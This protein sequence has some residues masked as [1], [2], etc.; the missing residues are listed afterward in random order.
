MAPTPQPGVPLRIVIVNPVPGV[1]LRVQSGRSDLLEPS[2]ASSGVVEFDLTLRAGS[3]RTGGQPNFL[4]AIA[5][6][7]PAARFIYVNAG[8]RCGQSGTPWDR[9]AKIP[10]TGITR[11][12]LASVLAGT[13]ARLEVRIHG[14]AGD[15]GPA[16][17]SVPL[18]P[19]GWQVVVDGGA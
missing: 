11:E 7:P 13:G 17:A 18:L 12:Q 6:G 1:F 3:P 19:P 5:Q 14:R 16:C 2:R 8:R 9:R 10:L 4:G 15:G